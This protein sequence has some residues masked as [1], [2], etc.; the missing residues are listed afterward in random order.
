MEYETIKKIIAWVFIGISSFLIFGT[1]LVS[2]LE[3]R[4]EKLIS[5][6]ILSVL[7]TIGWYIMAHWAFKK[8]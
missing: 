3:A 1:F 4:P 2:H 7:G 8:I 5:S 6:I